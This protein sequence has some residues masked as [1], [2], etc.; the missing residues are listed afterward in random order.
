[1]HQWLTVFRLSPLSLSRGQRKRAQK[2][3]AFMR[4]LAIGSAALKLKKQGVPAASLN[5]GEITDS[6]K[7]SM[8]NLPGKTEGTVSESARDR[9]P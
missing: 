8:D 1:M 9:L 3:D 4:K 5:L 6:L 7:F 2:K